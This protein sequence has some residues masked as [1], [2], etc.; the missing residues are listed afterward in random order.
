[1]S[2]EFAV[3]FTQWMFVRKS[4]VL[5]VKIRSILIYF[6]AGIIMALSVF[7]IG[8]LRGPGILTNLIQVV[9]GVIVYMGFITLTKEEFHMLIFS[10]IKALLV[11][12]H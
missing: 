10:K 5:K 7:Y 6:S 4:L 8:Y 2:A 3:V 1:M 9:F 11:R 12:A